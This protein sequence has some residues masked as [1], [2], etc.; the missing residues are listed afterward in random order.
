MD[1]R[2]VLQREGDHAWMRQTI[3]HGCGHR[4]NRAAGGH[5]LQPLLGIVRVVIQEIR[6]PAALLIE[7]P[8]GSPFRMH[9]RSTEKRLIED[10]SDAQVVVEGESMPRC[11]QYGH[12]APLDGQSA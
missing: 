12:R 6:W 11:D 9:V 1:Q 10:V 8:E 4:R 2:A 5:D 7:L 3:C